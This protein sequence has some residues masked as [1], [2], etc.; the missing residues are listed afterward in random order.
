MPTEE[1]VVRLQI[2]LQHRRAE[3][4][5]TGGL[6]AAC[7]PSVLLRELLRKGL[8]AEGLELAETAKHS[9]PRRQFLGREVARSGAVVRCIPQGACRNTWRHRGSQSLRVRPTHAYRAAS[10]RRRTSCVATTTLYPRPVL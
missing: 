7:R 8:E 2:M 9:A 3:A 6:N 5:E 4:I 10:R 1:R